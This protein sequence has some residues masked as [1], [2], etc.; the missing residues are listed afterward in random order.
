VGQ[1]DVGSPALRSV[2]GNHLVA[3]LDTGHARTYRLNNTTSLVTEDARELSFGILA[4]E[5][6]D[7]SVAQGVRDNLESDFASFG[8]RNGDNL[9]S[10]RLVRGECLQKGHG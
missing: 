2:A 3:D 4:R 5:G 6:V 10:Q 9:G 8:R 7:I 1:K